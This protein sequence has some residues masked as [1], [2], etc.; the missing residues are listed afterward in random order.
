M[1][2]YG[3]P[4]RGLVVGLTKPIQQQVPQEEPPE[5]QDE[6][7]E[8]HDCHMI[9]SSTRPLLAFQCYCMHLY[10]YGLEMHCWVGTYVASFIAHTVPCTLTCIAKLLLLLIL[11]SCF[12]D[13]E[14]G[15]DHNEVETV[16]RQT[17]DKNIVSKFLLASLST[18]D[19]SK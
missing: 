15:F 3:H 17:Q 4:R 1:E 13:D 5:D 2:Y 18:V 7:G 14:D 19:T 8:S 11:P 10:M 6:S 12:V 9:F 16:A